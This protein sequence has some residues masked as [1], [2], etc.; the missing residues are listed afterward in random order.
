MKNLKEQNL[1]GNDGHQLL[2]LHHT[3]ENANRNKRQ[4]KIYGWNNDQEV[5][6]HQTKENF[7]KNTNL[8]STNIFY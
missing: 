2:K 4:F 7:I 1:H 5:D 6:I 3:K 8:L